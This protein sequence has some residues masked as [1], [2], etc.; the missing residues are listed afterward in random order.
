MG[1][2]DQVLDVVSQHFD[3]AIADILSSRRAR[4]ILIAR[5][6]AMYLAHRMSG[7]TST[8]IGMRFGGRD[9]TSVELA[10]RGMQRL[11][12]SDPEQARLFLSLEGRASALLSNSSVRCDG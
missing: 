1:C 6:V 5:R 2:I 7:A 8:E 4:K 12:Q 11:A 9:Y 10:C 3:V